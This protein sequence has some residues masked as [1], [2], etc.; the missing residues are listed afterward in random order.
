MKNR[1]DLEDAICFT[2]LSR[3]IIP[4]EL[5]SEAAQFKNATLPSRVS[6]NRTLALADNCVAFIPDIEYRD[7]SGRNKYTLSSKS[8]RPI[9]SSSQSTNFILG[10]ETIR[11]LE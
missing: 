4:K 5:E 7:L 2:F 9:N 6:I 8:I 11:S 3:P 1:N 10:N